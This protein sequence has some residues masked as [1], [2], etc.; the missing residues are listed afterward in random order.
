MDRS[1]GSP[2]WPTSSGSGSSL[3]CSKRDSQSRNVD[4]RHCGSIPYRVRNRRDQQQVMITRLRNR[5][6]FATD[7]VALPFATLLAFV[8]RFEGWGWTATPYWA[9]A[10][11]FVGGATPIK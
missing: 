10:L 8:I 1:V 11:Y 3:A 2:L 4:V 7:L 5:L 9:L 6:F